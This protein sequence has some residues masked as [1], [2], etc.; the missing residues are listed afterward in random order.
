MACGCTP[1]CGSCT[2]CED[3]GQC[4]R[5]CRPGTWPSL[6]SRGAQQRGEGVCLP[7]THLSPAG[8]WFPSL[9][10]A[11]PGWGSW[12]SPAPPYLLQRSPDPPGV[13]GDPDGLPGLVGS[14]VV[15]TR[16]VLLGHATPAPV[17]HQPRGA[18]AARYA[19]GAELWMGTA[20]APALPCARGP[21]GTAR[22]RRPLTQSTSSVWQ[23]LRHSAPGVPAEA[24]LQSRYTMGAVHPVDGGS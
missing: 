18:H 22:P 11:F 1:T 16:A 5:G 9:C 23:L 15:Q 8:L 3:S 17:R 10:G 7:V 12:Q 2:C 20:S 19:V 14:L 6:L 4:A 21:R 24:L 13:A